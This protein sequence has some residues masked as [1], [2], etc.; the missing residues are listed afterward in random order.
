MKKTFV[1]SVVALGLL[2][3]LVATGCGSSPDPTGTSSS[4]APETTP[5]AIDIAAGIGGGN[6]RTAGCVPTGNPCTRNVCVGIEQVYRCQVES[7][8]YGTSCQNAA[9]CVM[10]GVC[11]GYGGCGAT[12]GGHGVC[13]DTSVGAEGR[14]VCDCAYGACVGYAPGGGASIYPDTRDCSLSYN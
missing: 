11:N 9:G 2:G 12:P 10:D 14:F 4:T 3:V 13:A 5:G 1:A 7:M 6:C 8:P